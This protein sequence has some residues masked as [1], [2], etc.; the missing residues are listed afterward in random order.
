MQPNH[1]R[2]TATIPAL[3]RRFTSNHNQVYKCILWLHI[4][5]LIQSVPKIRSFNACPHL[6]LIRSTSISK[7]NHFVRNWIV[8]GSVHFDPVHTTNLTRDNSYTRPYYGH[9]L[10]Y[11]LLAVTQSCFWISHPVVFGHCLLPIHTTKRS[12]L[13]QSKDRLTSAQNLLETHALIDEC[14][15][16]VIT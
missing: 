7:L 13:V 2:S 15:C 6:I 12:F 4:I 10:A 8:I 11:L 9:V 3:C 5:F 14:D 16:H 1:S